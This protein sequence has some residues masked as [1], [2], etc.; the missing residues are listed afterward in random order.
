[1]SPSRKNTLIGVAGAVAATVVGW[2]LNIINP[3]AP[4]P[5][6]VIINSVISKVDQVERPE[7]SEFTP[8]EIL[9]DNNINNVNLTTPEQRYYDREKH[10]K[11]ADYVQLAHILSPS[12]TA[13]QLYDIYIYLV[14]HKPRD[15]LQRVFR[16]VEKAEFFFGSYWGNGIFEGNRND[17]TIGVRVSAYGPFLATCKITFRDGRTRMLYRYVD[18]EMGKFLVKKST[19]EF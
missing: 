7:V 17:Q 13:G 2:A 6:D 14:R 18:F 1:M 8:T 9:L 16:D 19:E 12:D 10:Y 5:T 4:I 11:A 3:P 15:E